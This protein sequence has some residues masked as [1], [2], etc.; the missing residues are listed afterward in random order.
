MDLYHVYILKILIDG[1]YYIDFSK[2]IRRRLNE[3]NSGK[4]QFTRRKIPWELVYSENFYSK[5]EAL[6]REKFLKAQ[7]NH[8]FYER[9]IR[10]KF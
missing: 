4:S 5:T 7:R 6:K 2:D 8:D 3:H 9:L 10:N 1:S